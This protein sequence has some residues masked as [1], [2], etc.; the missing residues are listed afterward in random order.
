M[1][2]H[3]KFIVA[4]TITLGTLLIGLHIN[5][6]KITIHEVDPSYIAKGLEHSPRFRVVLG[7]RSSLHTTLYKGMM[8]LK[9]KA[10]NNG[11]YEII[12]PQ[13]LGSG[14]IEL[15]GYVLTSQEINS[16]DFSTKYIYRWR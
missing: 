5:K 1:S 4:S 3:F 11:V 10:I 15:I 8:T 16:L 7:E 6:N 12:V 9:S 13:T 14:D 2:K